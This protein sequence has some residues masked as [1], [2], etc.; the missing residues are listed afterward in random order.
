M[1]AGMLFLA[2]T[3]SFSSMGFDA[4]TPSGI[5]APKFV[6]SLPHLVAQQD[7]FLGRLITSEHLGNLVSSVV[8]LDD[9][10][11]LA[12]ILEAGATNHQHASVG[13]LRA[14]TAVVRTITSLPM[15]MCEIL[16]QIELGAIRSVLVQD[17]LMTGFSMMDYARMSKYINPD[18]PSPGVLHLLAFATNVTADSV[19]YMCRDL[20]RGIDISFTAQTALA[21]VLKE[22]VPHVRVDCPSS[23]DGCNLR[24]SL[25]CATS[26]MAEIVKALTGLKAIVAEEMGVLVTAQYRPGSWFAD[27][28]KRGRSAAD[29]HISVLQNVRRD[30][31]GRLGG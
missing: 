31:E 28:I 24:G 29:E 11:H 13:D 1:S 20:Q 23:A 3:S 14:I 22:N 5:P 16:R 12:T 18:S 10:A 30:L 25:L 15:T 2:I 26:A 6:F 19:S 9:V 8:A 4:Y 21:H 7:L 27:E 17:T